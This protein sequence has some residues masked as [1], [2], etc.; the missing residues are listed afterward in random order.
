MPKSIKFG[1]LSYSQYIYKHFLKIY[2]QYVAVAIQTFL[3]T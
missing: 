1:S 2:L 3:E